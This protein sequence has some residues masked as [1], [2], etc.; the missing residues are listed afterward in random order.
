M[1]LQGVR[2]FRDDYEEHLLRGRC[3]CGLQHS[4]PCTVVC[5]AHVGRARLHRPGQGWPV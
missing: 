1:V 2:G 3:I 5:P 4:I